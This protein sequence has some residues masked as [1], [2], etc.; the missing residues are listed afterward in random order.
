ME[1]WRKVWRDGLA[2]HLSTPAL[3]AL[4]TA[5]EEDSKKLIQGATTIPPPLQCVQDWPA[6]AGCVIGFCGIIDKG[7]FGKATVGEVEE[8][9][10]QTCFAIDHDLGEPAAWR[11]FLNWADETP[12]DE[13]RSL[14]LAEVKRTLANRGIDLLSNG[15]VYVDVAPIQGVD[16]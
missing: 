13:M 12:R 7:G 4:A 2:M 8:M 15:A 11:W 3:E 9:F 6:E 16:Q 1:S 10:A 14:L 5:L